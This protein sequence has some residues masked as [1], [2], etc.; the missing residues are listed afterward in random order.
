MEKVAASSALGLKNI[1]V[2]TD[3]S[4]V[5]GRA[6]RFAAGL[7]CRFD[8]RLYAVHAGGPVDY[9]V[10]AELWREAEEAARVAAV[11]LGR[12]LHDDFPGIESEILEGAGPAWRVINNAVAEKKID[13]IVL[14]THG[15]TGV[16][17]L[18][19]GSV[20]EEILRRAACPV[21]CLGP[22]AQ[23][24]EETPPT[25]AEI[26]YATDFSP[27]AYHA[28]RHAFAWANELGAR[29]T[30]LH[31]LTDGARLNFGRP[32]EPADAAT[33]LLERQ[34]PAEGERPFACELRVVPGE[35]AEKILETAGSLPAALIV[36]GTRGFSGI[37]GAAT[38]LPVSTLHKV[39][40][41]APCAVLSAR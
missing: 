27:E 9:S 18:L 19:L 26:L 24:W 22:N 31:V 28:A 17:K 12:T 20:A 33:R 38:H 8:G 15:R 16:P 36:I 41:R 10:P 29:L 34:L 25:G 32:Q 40:S 5:S 7:A 35:P 6:I 3:Y 39:I 21:L 30:L 13:L 14:A 2:A 37:P 1:L 11:E 4:P 23:V